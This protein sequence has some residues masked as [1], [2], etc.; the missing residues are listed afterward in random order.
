MQ[1]PLE[2]SAHARPTSAGA[3]RQPWILIGHRG[4]SGEAPENTLAAFELALTEGA[5]GIEFDTHLSCDG[6]PVVLHD[7]RLERTTNGSGF[8]FEH[9]LASL[10]RLDAGSWFNRRWPSRAR[11]GYA[12]ERIPT[13]EETL[14]WVKRRRCRA[15]VEIKRGRKPYPRIE[16]KVLDAVRRTATGRLAAIISFEL[17]TLARLRRLDST[18]ALGID[19]TRPLLAILGARRVGASTLLPHWAFASQRFIRRAHEH[20][21]EVV[22][23]GLDR[24][25]SARRLLA[26]GVDGIITNF[27]AR[28]AALR[29]S[30]H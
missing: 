27:P 1:S 3:W 29:P 11:P 9:T 18:I 12:N 4:A 16:A 14:D 17:R 10:R 21:L 30:G 24:E 8:V 6:V 13:L 2:P 25:P 19:L 5:D 7:A 22:V 26:Q 23:W 15:F 28:L 20:S